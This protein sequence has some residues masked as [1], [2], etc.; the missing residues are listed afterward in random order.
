MKEC[1][2]IYRVDGM[3]VTEEMF[4]SMCKATGVDEYP[5]RRLKPKMSLLDEDEF[6]VDPGP[7]QEMEDGKSSSRFCNA[8]GHVLVETWV[9]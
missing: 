4:T 6:E 5:M 3:A 9:K 8:G 2:K 1:K 7:W